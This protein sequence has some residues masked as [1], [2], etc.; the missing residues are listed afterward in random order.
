MI[1]IINYHMGN[2][3]SIT[4]MLKRIGAMSTITSDPAEIEVAEKF[5]L[6]GVGHFDKAMHNLT[7]L[8]LV[9]VLRKKVLEDKVPV[10]GI[11]LGMQLLCKNSEEGSRDG[12][13]FVDAYVKRFYFTDE[14]GLKIPQMG[15]NLIKPEK[16]SP[17]LENNGKDSR[18]YFVHSYHVVCNNP[19]DVLTS[20]YHGYRFT[21]SFERDNIIGVQFHPEK[22]HRF[23]MQLLKNF[24]ENY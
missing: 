15:W 24:V 20:T 22:S 1:T 12:L 6:P 18:F 11:C 16:A 9:D 14:I 8:G 4:N 21:S 13:G 3:G 17:L 10:L 23:G 2:L 19:Q 5:I 7:H